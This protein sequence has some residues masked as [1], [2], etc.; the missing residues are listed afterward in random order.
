MKED[1]IMFKHI[2]R[3]LTAVFLLINSN[4]I[5][6]QS[7]SDE[8]P[9][10]WV[11]AYVNAGRN[12][13]SDESQ[14]RGITHILLSALKFTADENGNTNVNSF[15]F[16]DSYTEGNINHII[17][18]AYNKKKII[19]SI[20]GEGEDEIYL[21][22]ITEQ[23]KCMQFA[24]NLR[25]FII[26]KGWWNK[27]DGIDIDWEYPPLPQ[28]WE[29]W[30][31]NLFN[32]LIDA[33]QTEFRDKNFLWS[34]AVAGSYNTG[35]NKGWDYNYLRD[36]MNFCNLMGYDID[37]RAEHNRVINDLNEIINKGFPKEKIV[38][39]QPF[40]F[41]GSQYDLQKQEYKIYTYEEV[42][43]II[44][45][46]GIEVP[47]YE[48]LVANSYFT[49]N[50]KG[51]AFVINRSA[52]YERAKD[53]VTRQVGGIGC[54][55]LTQ[56]IPVSQNFFQSL[57]CAISTACGSVWE[58]QNNVAIN[59]LKS[60]RSSEWYFKIN[61]PTSGSTLTVS[62]NGSGDCDL[63]IKREQKPTLSTYDSRSVTAGSNETITISNAS[64]GTWYI[65]LY[66]NY[67]YS[68]VTLKASSIQTTGDT[69]EPDNSYQQAKVIT[70]NTS[71]QAHTIEPV[72]DQD[73]MKFLATRGTQYI[74]ETHAVSGNHCDTYLY[75]YSTNRTTEIDHDDDDGEGTLSK[76]IWTCNSSGTYYIK[77]RGYD[78]YSTTGPYGIT[79]NSNTT[80]NPPRNLVATSGQNGNVPL[81]WQ[82]P[83]SLLL[84]GDEPPEKLAITQANG[85]YQTAMARAAAVSMGVTGYNMYRSTSS[86]GTFSKINSS[87]ITATSYT[88]YNV[89]N[90]TT[91]YYKATTV[92]SN[93]TGESGYSNIASATPQGSQR[94]IIFTENFEN[95]FP[96]ST[97]ESADLNAVSG[98]D[99]WDDQS[100]S[101]GA[102]VREGNRSCYCADISDISGQQ[103]DDN[104]QSYFKLL[105]G[106]NVSSYTDV[107]FS[108][109]IWYDTESG[110]DYVKRYY[111]ND[112]I[113][114]TLAAQ[115]AGNS[116]GWKRYTISLMNFTNYWIKF[117]F[118]SDGSVHNYEGVY[119]DS[120]II[121]G[122]NSAV[123]TKSS[124]EEPYEKLVD[125]EIPEILIT[126]KPLDENINN[127]YVPKQFSLEQNYPNPF[128]PTTTI[129]YALP[130]AAHVQVQ[131]FDVNGRKVKRLVDQVCNAGVYSVVW[132][133]T[134]EVQQKVS[135]GI[136]ICR[137][138]A[139]EVV[140]NRKLVLT[141]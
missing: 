42:W 92:Y 56:D 104:M 128:N 138:S 97:W 134:D 136:Y 81:S 103:Y 51:D 114:Y 141:K 73:W 135:S 75:L 6:S 1:K 55:E 116:N 67:G 52:M 22:R 61:V 78:V 26:N 46:F 8:P 77:V 130:E 121:T 112:G 24:Q 125:G 10:K 33:L 74:I 127:H 85:E 88:D 43:D 132:D 124:E 118:Y 107:K 122:N 72:G 37:R 82:A 89:T 111:S 100:I 17:T 139:G 99:Y 13:I 140:L 4:I 11:F 9:N 87:L 110:Y 109:L 60:T 113:N 39:L 57:R 21:K 41:Y 29:W 117:E 53:L 7:L 47:Y 108:F 27:I 119:I 93:P 19:I 91:Y 101:Q 50:N 25:N 98:Y 123:I 105:P 83:S 34:F 23:N 35:A 69:Y 64:S 14:L 20:D 133:A 36:K 2:I 137:F 70:V 40:Y 5:L 102:R 38:V 96:G 76:L 12:S 68:G 129:S 62:T 65:M 115:W 58:L 94:V 120:L 131:I 79:V 84:V 126:N 49:P 28:L 18:I 48:S 45:P 95:P 59:N 31:P 80:F 30:K 3:V 66:G 15:Y 71:Q 106:V 32:R 63:Y 86:T 16:A 44:D 54:W 90:G